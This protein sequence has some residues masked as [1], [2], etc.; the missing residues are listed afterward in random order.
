M[1]EAKNNARNDANKESELDIFGR[2]LQ[3][4]LWLKINLKETKNANGYNFEIT[5]EGIDPYTKQWH[6]QVIQ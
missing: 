6:F 1:E 4:D 2:V 5:M 3:A